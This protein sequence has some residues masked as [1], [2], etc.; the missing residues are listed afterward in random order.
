MMMSDL[1]GAGVLALSGY[2]VHAMDRVIFRGK[3][4]FQFPLYAVQN[5]LV[6]NIGLLSG[7]K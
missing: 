4:Y 2:T 6:I 1:A 5:S 3:L 7:W